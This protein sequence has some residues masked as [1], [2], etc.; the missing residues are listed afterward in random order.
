MSNPYD[1]MASGFSSGEAL[2]WTA[3]VGSIAACTVWWDLMMPVP[4]ANSGLLLKNMEKFGNKLSKSDSVVGLAG[5]GMQLMTNV[6]MRLKMIITDTGK[7]LEACGKVHESGVAAQRY[8]DELDHLLKSITPEVWQGDDQAK[9]QERL[10]KLKARAEGHV[11]LATLTAALTA[12]VGTLRFIQLAIAA[13]LAGA[14]GV[15]SVAYW[16]AMAIPF[17]QGVAQGIRAAG[18]G[19]S[20]MLPNIIRVMDEI[21]VKVGQAHVACA[22]ALV[23]FEAIADSVQLDNADSLK[24]LGGA[25]VETVGDIAKKLSK[26]QIAVLSG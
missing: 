13:A 3:F 20:R 6:P 18:V 14:L 25:A 4:A 12:V 23:A 9:F 24:D 15:M 26:G 8:V 7:M 22:A 19:L 21:M 1:G 2:G 16:V 11:S 17:G 10:E 5:N